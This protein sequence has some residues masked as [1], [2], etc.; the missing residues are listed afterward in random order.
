MKNDILTLCAYH[1]SGRVVFAYRAGFH[2]DGIELS[3]VDPGKGKSRL[4]GGADTALIQ[5]ILGGNHPVISPENRNKAI[6]V[7]QNLMDVYCAGTCTR[8]YLEEEGNIGELVELDVPVQDEKP[9]GAIQ[10]F[11]TEINPGHDPAFP[12]KRM[13][14]IF[15][16]L[17]APEVWKAIQSLASTAVTNGE[18]LLGRFEIEDALMAGGLRV[19][20]AASPG[21][22]VG[23]TEAGK[24]KEGPET[25][26]SKTIE[27]ESE[28]PADILLKDFF[29]KV[30]KD[31]GEEE[32]A[33]ATQHVKDI[34]RKY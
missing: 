9:I 16:K 7:A 25:R 22:S 17:R 32:V 1:E 4:N 13:A 27:F 20:R 5:Q 33:A 6:E 34:I 26:A 8:I 2:C 31:W 19:Q 29:R 3:A 14:V 18:K 23:L 28:S 12:S 15:K 30:R 21:F 10:K 24:K 11:L